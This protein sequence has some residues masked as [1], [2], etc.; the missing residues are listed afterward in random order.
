MLH[1]NKFDVYVFLASLI[2]FIHFISYEYFL[3]AGLVLGF[4]LGVVMLEKGVGG[5]TS[6]ERPTRRSGQK[7]SHDVQTRR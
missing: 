3:D 6:P 2:V 5:L 7:A 1:T 4:V